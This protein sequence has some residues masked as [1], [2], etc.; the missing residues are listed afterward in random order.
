MARVGSEASSPSSTATAAICRR[1]R[2]VETGSSAMVPGK[3]KAPPAKPDAAVK[4]RCNQAD[5]DHPAWPTPERRA[6]F[7]AK[8]KALRTAPPRRPSTRSGSQ[9]L[10]AAI[11]VPASEANWVANDDFSKA[12]A[13]RRRPSTA[14]DG[15]ASRGPSN[16]NGNGTAGADSSDSMSSS[17]CIS[18]LKRCT[19]SMSRVI[20]AVRL[21]MRWGEFV[22]LNRLIAF[23]G[24][25][26]PPVPHADNRIGMPGSRRR[27]AGGSGGSTLRLRGPAL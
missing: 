10:R 12:S 27:A 6:V 8:N 5:R 11:G 25:T 19:G 14:S 15:S 23:P 7:A 4:P 13:A 26:L 1:S 21:G 22:A 24:I 20:I 18:L 2:L 9:A 16:E 3:P 17:Q